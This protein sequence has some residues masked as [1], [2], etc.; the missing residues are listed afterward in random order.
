ME[1]ILL[2][3]VRKLGI[4]GSKVKVKDGFGRNY[5]IPFS[6]AVRATKDNISVFEAKKAVIDSENAKN[7][8][9]AQEKAA[10]LDNLQVYIIRQAADDGRLFGSVGSKDI[11]VAIHEK[12]H[13]E[14]ERNNVILSKPIKTIASHD[15]VVSLHPEVNIV[16]KVNVIR[17]EDEI[18][19]QD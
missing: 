3:S 19:K 9:A 14:I 10:K 15:V 12:G 13:T 17:S 16:V 18:V 6:K 2:E 5:L 7:L 4:A 11:I 8:L 1:V